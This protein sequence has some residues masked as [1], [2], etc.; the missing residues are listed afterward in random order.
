MFEIIIFDRLFVEIS[1][2]ITS[3]QHGFFPKRS[4]FTNLTSF[5]QYVHDAINNKSQVD[6]L[7]TDMEK[8][9]DRVRHCVILKTLSQMDVPS[10]LIYLLQ[11]YLSCRFQYVE[12]KG[13]KSVVYKSTSGVPQSS[14]LSPLLFL[15]TINGIIDNLESAK[16]LLFADDFKC[17]SVVDS[18]EDCQSL[19]SD[20]C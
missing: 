18:L 3:C 17:F 6:V 8:A 13:C 5:C 2:K 20:F 10:Y 15:T 9:F 19:K 4:T 1:S 14:N 16:G 12:I 7:Y 11:S